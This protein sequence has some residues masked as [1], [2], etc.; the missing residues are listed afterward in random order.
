MKKLCG[1]QSVENWHGMDDY[2]SFLIIISACRWVELRKSPIVQ[3]LNTSATYPKPVCCGWSVVPHVDVQIHWVNP[4]TRLAH[5]FSWAKLGDCDMI[6]LYI[7]FMDIFDHLRNEVVRG[8]CTDSCLKLGEQAL[9][10]VECND[11]PP[12]DLAEPFLWGPARFGFG[13]IWWLPPASAQVSVGGSSGTP[14]Q[15]LCPTFLVIICHFSEDSFFLVSN[16]FL[17]CFF[18]FNFCWYVC[19]WSR[20]WWTI[21]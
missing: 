18:F 8:G 13:W 5:G 14:I 12:G 1:C 20:I 11:Q 7:I 2:L 17:V 16:K 9:E 4:F 15:M 19:F 6:I 3:S 10:N 21:A